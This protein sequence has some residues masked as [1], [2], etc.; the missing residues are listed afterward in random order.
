M[1]KLLQ[2]MI[3]MCPRTLAI[4]NKIFHSEIFANK[5]IEKNSKMSEISD[6]NVPSF[7]PSDFIWRYVQK[8]KEMLNQIFRALKMLYV[9]ILTMTLFQG[10]LMG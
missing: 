3:K 6:P 4:A 8:K 5:K 7:Q 1:K 9:I 2:K 10:F